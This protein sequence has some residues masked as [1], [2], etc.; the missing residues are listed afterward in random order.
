MMIGGA[1][2]GLALLRWRRA[3]LV[4]LAGGLLLFSALFGIQLLAVQ[5]EHD[6]IGTDFRLYMSFGAQ[7]ISTGDPYTPNPSAPELSGQYRYPPPAL[8]LFVAFQFLPAPLWWIVPI[9]ITGWIIAWW[10]PAIWSWPLFPAAF[11]LGYQFFITAGSGNTDIWV[12]MVIA[13]ATR[14]PAASWL[15]VA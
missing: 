12:L 1:S 7:A 2:L 9:A 4:G 5:G 11:L 14:W 6:L 8:Y 3:L 10:R 13:L 15:L